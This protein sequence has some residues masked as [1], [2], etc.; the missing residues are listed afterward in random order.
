MT[1]KRPATNN[2]IR[3]LIND[4][5]LELKSD[6]GKIS[7]KVDGLNKTVTDNEIKQAVSSTKIGMLIAGITILTSAIT[8][9][10]ISRLTRGQL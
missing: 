5:R 1:A 6:I 4:V 9:I 3:D 2:N 10:A 7:D 8:T